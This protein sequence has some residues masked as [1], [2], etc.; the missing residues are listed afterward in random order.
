MTPQPLVR[1]GKRARHVVMF[2]GG[3]AS[4]ATAK[5]VAAIHGTEH[6]TLLFADT[7]MEDEDTYRFLRA[8]AENVGGQFVRVA[9]G[10]DIWQV[11]RDVKFLGNTRIDPCSRVLKREIMRKW[12]DANC[13]PETTTVYLGIDWSEQH[14]A[15]RYERYWQPYRVK[16]PL[17]L[18]PLVT[19]DRMLD[20]AR[21]EGLPS[22]RL[23]DLGFAHA[24]CGGGCVKAGQAQF[25]LL[26]RTLPERYAWW[27]E[28]EREIRAELGKDITILRDRYV[29]NGAEVL[30]P[31]TLEAFR[32]RLQA[33]P[34]LF[35]Q[36]EWGA[37]DCTNPSDDELEMAA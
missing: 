9:D 5:R 17:T 29:R 31:I 15:V 21:A 27:E 4:W 1:Q 23:Y 12:V 6:L 25:E 28:N 10:R 13:D 32:L 8:A 35:D 7:M 14:R 3:V 24:N 19:K 33:Q 18:P 2:S 34:E 26:L 36:D 20:Q 11:F 22:Q 37:C 16:C 30:K